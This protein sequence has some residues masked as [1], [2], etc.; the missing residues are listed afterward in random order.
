MQNRRDRQPRRYVDFP[1]DDLGGDGKTD[2]DNDMAKLWA[3]V[4]DPPPAPSLKRP[5]LPKAFDDVVAR[6]TAKNPADRFNLVGDLIDRY[7]RRLAHD[8][9]ASLRIDEGVCRAEIDS[10]IAGEKTEK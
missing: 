4:Q 3:H 6:A 10:E 2:K 5:G 8:D 7:D 9:A 1:D